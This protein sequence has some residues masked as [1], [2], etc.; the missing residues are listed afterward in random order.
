MPQRACKQ[1]AHCTIP[2]YR[3]PKLRPSRP[4]RPHH[5]D[6]QIHLWRTPRTAILFQLRNARVRQY[7]VNLCSLGKHHLLSSTSSFAVASYPPALY[8][9]HVSDHIGIFQ[10]SLA[11]PIECSSTSSLAIWTIAVVNPAARATIELDRKF[12]VIF[13]GHPEIA[14]EVLKKHKTALGNP[15]SSL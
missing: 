3:Q 14:I 9:Q 15:S 12:S 4:A 2:I 8:A 10:A 7:D 11:C 5:K 13:S 1:T 6:T